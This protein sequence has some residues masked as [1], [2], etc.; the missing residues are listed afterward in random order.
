M[1]ADVMTDQQ[2]RHIVA[3]VNPVAGASK[4][5]DALRRMVYLL[6]SAGMRVEMKA[7]MAAGHAFDLSSEAASCADA[8]PSGKR[9]TSTAT[10]GVKSISWPRSPTLSK[11]R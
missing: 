1:I 9:I 11:T 4:Q 10:S 5:K 7:T 3:I 8:V 2:P 6:Q